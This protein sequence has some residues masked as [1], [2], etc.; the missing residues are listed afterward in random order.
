MI[1][2][3]ES[4][5]VE[6]GHMWAEK[7]DNVDLTIKLKTNNQR[8]PR[9]AK[10]GD[11]TST[12]T[13]LSPDTDYK[14]IWPMRRIPREHCLWQ[15]RDPLKHYLHPVWLQKQNLRLISNANIQVRSVQ[16]NSSICLPI[17]QQAGIG[18]SEMGLQV[19]YKNPLHYYSAA[20][21]IPVS[22]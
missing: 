10:R 20:G 4:K 15:R 6:H 11:F 7:A 3:G 5:I 22:N 18:I 13:D 2:L 9:P 14:I 8:E 17:T 19:M 1:D 16:W 12:I 21:T